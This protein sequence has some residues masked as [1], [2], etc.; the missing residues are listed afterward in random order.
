MLRALTSIYS[1]P[2]DAGEKLITHPQS[3]IMRRKYVTRF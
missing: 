1:Q 2:I 3:V